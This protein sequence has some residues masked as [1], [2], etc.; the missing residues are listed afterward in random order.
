MSLDDALAESGLVSRNR[1]I[2]FVTEDDEKRMKAEAEATRKA[3][4]EMLVGDQSDSLMKAVNWRSGQDTDANAAMTEAEKQTV[5]NDT[6]PLWEKIK[7]QS[8]QK[9]AEWERENLAHR[10]PAAMEADDLEFFDDISFR[11]KKEEEDRKEAEESAMSS[12]RNAVLNKVTRREPVVAAKP[13]PEQPSKPKP[14]KR[15]LLVT[16]AKPGQSKVAKIEPAPAEASPVIEEKAPEMEEKESAM[17][18]LLG[19]D[20]DSSE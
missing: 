6:R 9:Q 15:K 4:A 11:K 3:E 16:R 14:A 8:D 18:G 2:M 1:S 7:E 20:Y 17:S 13:E 19:V 12:F 5:A 10:P